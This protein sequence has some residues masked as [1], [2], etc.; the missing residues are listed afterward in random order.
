MSLL[1]VSGL[2]LGVLLAPRLGWN[3]VPLGGSSA[4]W[5][6]SSPKERGSGR[7]VTQNRDAR[8]FDSIHLDYPA[9]VLVRQGTTESLMVEAEDNIAA[10]IRTQVVNHVL[11]I[12]S[13]DDHIDYIAATRPVNITITV[14]DLS[15]LD[16]NSAGEVTVEGL[17]ATALAVTLDGAG[18]ISLKDVQ[19][20]SLDGRLKG[21]GALQAEGTVKDLNVLVDGM[22]SF[23]GGGLRAQDVTVS[24][25][26][27][28]S[29]TVWADVSLAAHVNGMGSVNYAGDAQ[30][31]KSV[32]GLG[33]VNFTGSK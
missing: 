24:L 29:A 27:L 28:G 21:V 14:K 31:T 32:N 26:G 17:H 1:V 13:V 15:E 25:N 11:E 6:L 16:F 3:S 12:D 2:F 10:A 23:K 20:G 8:D 19:L 33:T 7:V 22:G 30:V 9:N 5:F 4:G 18:N